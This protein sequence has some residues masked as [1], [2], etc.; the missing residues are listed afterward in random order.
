[1]LVSFVVSRD[2]FC[3]GFCLDFDCDVCFVADAGR[4]ITLEESNTFVAACGSDKNI[5]VGLRNTQ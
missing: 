1:M 5:F 3:S 2:N 4:T